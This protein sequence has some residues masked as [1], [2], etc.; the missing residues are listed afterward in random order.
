MKVNTHPYSMR[1]NENEQYGGDALFHLTSKP[2]R[3]LDQ[4]TIILKRT[5][6]QW[7]MMIISRVPGYAGDI[8]HINTETVSFHPKITGFGLGATE[9]GF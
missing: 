3:W 9:S 7:N 6:G 1:N 4:L 5:E 2:G 8:N